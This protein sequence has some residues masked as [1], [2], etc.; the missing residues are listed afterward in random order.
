[1]SRQQHTS[2]CAMYTVPETVTAVVGDILKGG[3]RPY[4]VTYP[5][6]FSGDGLTEETSI[7]FPMNKWMGCE[8][9]QVGQMVLLNNVQLFEQG[10]RAVRARPI[11]P[12]SSNQQ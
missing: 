7:T 4:V 11:T 2:D 9:P 10:W 6:N 8:P 1:M 5:R 3:R 12:G